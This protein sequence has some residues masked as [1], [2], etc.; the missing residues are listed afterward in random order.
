MLYALCSTAYLLLD[1]M[2]PLEGQFSETTKFQHSTFRRF[3]SYDDY[4]YLFSPGFLG[5]IVGGPYLKNMLLWC[6]GAYIAL[7]ILKAGIFLMY[8]A[9]HLRQL[10]RQEFESVKIPRYI[11]LTLLVTALTIYTLISAYHIQRTTLTGDEPHYLLITHSLWH[12]QDTN[13]Y[14]NYRDCDYEAFFTGMN[15]VRPGE[16]R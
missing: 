15:C 8:V 6:A 16:T 4:T 3:L 7:I 10:T 5:L 14:N 11:P 9:A 2:H 1:G 12:D 13:L